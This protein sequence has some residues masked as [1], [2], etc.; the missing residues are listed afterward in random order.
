M[1]LYNDDLRLAHYLK[2]WFYRICHNTKYSEQRREFLEWISTA[3]Q[4]QL[5]EFENA[6][7]LTGIGAMRYSM[8]LNMR[9]LQ[10]VLQKASTTK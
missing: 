7:P 9:T 1:L 10:T 2:E 8:L 3:E 6:L 4:S 5:T